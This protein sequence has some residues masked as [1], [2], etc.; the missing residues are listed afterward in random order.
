MRGQLLESCPGRDREIENRKWREA[1]VG[2]R[3]EGREQSREM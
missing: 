3:V 2:Q 1:R